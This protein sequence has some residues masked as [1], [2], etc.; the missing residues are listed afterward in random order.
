MIC[1]N[2]LDAVGNTPVVR[3][4]RMTEEGSAEILVKVESL[5]VGGSYMTIFMW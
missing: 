2:I 3:L 1:E 5:N 4:N